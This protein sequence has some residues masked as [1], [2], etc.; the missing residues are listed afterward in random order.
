[1]FKK[2]VKFIATFIIVFFI[3]GAALFLLGGVASSLKVRCKLQGDQLYTCQSH[4]AILGIPFTTVR[5]DRVSAVEHELK[6]EGG[7]TTKRCSDRAYFITADGGRILV[8]GIYIDTDQVPKMADALN[9]LMAEKTTPIDAA[10]SPSTFASVVTLSVCSCLFILF[11]FI[12]FITLF[13]KDA[14]DLESRAIDLRRAG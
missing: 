2:I 14:K 3:G 9:S 13:G 8:S 6:C 5:A 12:A 1:M 4:D 7:G 11:I 10:F